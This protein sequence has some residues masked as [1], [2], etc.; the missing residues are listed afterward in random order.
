MANSISEHQCYLQ[1]CFIRDMS[2]FVQ[3]LMHYQ[4]DRL[5]TKSLAVLNMFFSSKMDLFKT[6]V[7]AQVVNLKNLNIKYYD[8]TE[9]IIIIIFGGHP[10]TSSHLNPLSLVSFR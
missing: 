9:S 5:V 4:Y 10:T 2:S 1:F 3:D 7:R 6:A 8:N